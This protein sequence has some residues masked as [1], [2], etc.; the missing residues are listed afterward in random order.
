MTK[1]EKFINRE[2]QKRNLKSLEDFVKKE[3]EQT[4]LLYHASA[5]TWE[6]VYYALIFA[7][8]MRADLDVVFFAALFHDLGYL[9]PITWQHER[10]SVLL[11][12]SVQRKYK[13]SQYMAQI[14]ECIMATSFK[15]EAP[16]IEAKTVKAADLMQFALDGYVPRAHLYHKEA[17]LDM[18]LKQFVINTPEVMRDWLSQ[19]GTKVDFLCDQADELGREGFLNNYETFSYLKDI[20][21]GFDDLEFEKKY[22][23]FLDLLGNLG[24]Q[25]GAPMKGDIQLKI[26]RKVFGRTRQARRKGVKEL[27]AENKALARKDKLLS[28]VNRNLTSVLD[29]DLV[30]SRTIA[31]SAEAVGAQAITLYEVDNDGDIKFSHVHYDVPA[32]KQNSPLKKD[33]DKKKEKLLKMKLKPGQGIVGRVISSGEPDI[34]EDVT[35]DK[36]H[37]EQVSSKLGFPVR[38]MITVPL[39]TK[40]RIVGA[41]QVINKK[42]RYNLFNYDDLKLL[43]EVAAIAGIAIENACLYEDIILSLARALEERD[44]YTRGHSDRV[45]RYAVAIARRLGFAEQGLISLK[46]AGLL[47]DI[48][49][50]GIEDSILNKPGK[51]TDAEYEKIKEHPAGGVRIVSSQLMDVIPSI[52]YHHE[53]YDGTGYPDKLKGEEIPLQARILAV[54]DVFDALTSDRSYRPAMKVKDAFKILEKDKSAHFDPEIVDIFKEVYETDIKNIE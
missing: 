43:E 23:L 52:K 44:Y 12:A 36:T 22:Q 30:I 18:P 16:S 10:D 3:F 53:K 9:Q 21:I 51:L 54:A 19:N 39:K 35:K 28:A 5:H 8:E 4:T 11:A 13:F 41:V 7:R 33:F 32:G 26:A 50:M 46:R 45:S 42:G 31:R 25:T 37:Y 29:F 27:S 20:S 47:H 2:F 6:T 15:G 48:G 34:I 17:R 1:I 38:S 49:K 14:K 24:L 40:E